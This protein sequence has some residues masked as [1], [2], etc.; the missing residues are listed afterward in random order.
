MSFVDSG[1]LTAGLMVVRNSAPELAVRCSRLI[2][3]GDYRFFYDPVEQLMA[4]GYYV[5]LPYC[6]NTVTGCSTA[7]RGWAA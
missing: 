1:W 4:H 6:P 5:N 3:R 2:N 7:K